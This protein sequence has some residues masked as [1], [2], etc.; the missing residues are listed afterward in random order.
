MR[1]VRGHSYV[2]YSEIKVSET[3]SSRTRDFVLHGNAELEGNFREEG[4]IK[5]KKE[6][7]IKVIIYTKSGELENMGKFLCPAKRKWNARE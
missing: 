1:G 4:M 5:Y 3:K 7:N 6:M 2:G